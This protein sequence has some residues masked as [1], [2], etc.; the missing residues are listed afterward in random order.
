MSCPIF[1]ILTFIVLASLVRP[2]GSPFRGVGM[3]FD[4][5]HI[6][7][8]HGFL[9]SELPSYRVPRRLKQCDVFKLYD[10]CFFGVVS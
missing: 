10:F 4:D 3:G 5:P 7:L 1:F 9:K 8:R 2:L 6:R